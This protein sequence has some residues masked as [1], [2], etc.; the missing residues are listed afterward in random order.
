MKRLGISFT[1]LV[2]FFSACNTGSTSNFKPK[3]L[4]EYGVPLTILAP[5]SVE[6][7][8][9]DWIVRK[10]LSIRNE[11]ENFY[12]QLW[13]KNAKSNNLEQSKNEVL[14]EVKAERYFSKVINEDE[15]G[16]IFEKQIDSTTTEYNFRYIKLQGDKEFIF[17]KGLSG[18]YSLKDIEAMYEAVKGPQK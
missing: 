5:D 8:K 2:L 3:D 1:L 10:G 15:G 13:I 18:L 17:Q 11:A 9:E 6:V 16:F 14:S 4:L 12:V 7:K